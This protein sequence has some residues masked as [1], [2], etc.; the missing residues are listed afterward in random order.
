MKK[1]GFEMQNQTAAF[2]I[3]TPS[4]GRPHILD[5]CMAPGGYLEVALAINPG[6]GARGFCLPESDGGHKVFL[7]QASRSRA[8]LRYMDIT[9]LAADM[10]VENILEHHPDAGRFLSRQ[11]QPGEEF[12]FA[13]CD[14]HVL[15]THDRADYRKDCE[16][17]RLITTQLALSLEHLAPGGTMIVLLHKV[18]AW[19]SVL[20]LKTFSGFSRIR[21]YKPMAG[22]R[23]RSSFYMIATHIQSKH[24]LAIKAVARWKQVWKAATFGQDNGSM[25]ALHEEE[26]SAEEVIRDFGEELVRMGR[27]VWKNQ[28]EALA[29]A[30]FITG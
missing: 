25:L 15:R 2:K 21:L 5:M 14:G 19:D 10:G 8:E 11:F 1:I 7:S 3:E 23:V 20:V 13:L 6:I 22:H 17:Q 26:P 4:T 29:S 30:P 28:A 27:D 12:G 16:A 18:D 24:P 9:M